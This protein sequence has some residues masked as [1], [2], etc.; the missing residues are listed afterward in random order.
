MNLVEAKPEP[1]T[2]MSGDLMEPAQDPDLR[3]ALVI[4][5]MGDGYVA[6]THPMPVAS[7]MAVGASAEAVLQRFAEAEDATNSYGQEG[8]RFVPYTLVGDPAEI[9]GGIQVV[10]GDTEAANA[11]IRKLI[12]SVQRPSDEA[13]TDTGGQEASVSEIQPADNGQEAG[14]SMKA[15]LALRR[16][17]FGK[18]VATVAAVAGG[19]ALTEAPAALAEASTSGNLEAE[20]KQSILTQPDI[21]YSRIRHPGKVNQSIDI[22]FH[23]DNVLPSECDKHWLRIVSLQAQIKHPGQGW[24]NESGS[25]W[26]TS[27]FGNNLA[28]PGGLSS[29]NTFRLHKLYYRPGDKLRWRLRLQDQDIRTDDIVGTNIA[30]YPVTTPQEG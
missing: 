23:L 21:K 26:N 22:K 10:G 3:S 25:G 15:L 5:L 30:D 17:R 8:E 19:L 7:I 6:E 13:R 18:A 20:C 29:V 12:G 9:F 1:D 27:P 28:G 2:I 24:L 4:D 14:L 16:T 11:Y